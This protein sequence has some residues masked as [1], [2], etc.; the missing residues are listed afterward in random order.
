MNFI[1]K[2]L[3]M[4]AFVLLYLGVYLVVSTFI[5]VIYE[6]I[7]IIG[8]MINGS[9]GFD[10]NAFQSVLYQHSV[11]FTI[12]SAIVVIPIYWFIMWLRKLKMRDECGF[13]RIKPQS[14]LISALL[15]IAL[16]LPVDFIVSFLSIDKLSPGTEQIFNAMFSNNSVLVLILSVGLAAPILEEI[17]FRGLIFSELRRHLPI[18]IAIVIQGLL[19]GA[20]H[21]NWTQF[22]Y[23]APLG[24]LFGVV[25]IWVRSISA[26][27]I[28][29]ILFNSAGILIGKFFNEQ[30]IFNWYFVVLSTI[31]VIMLMLLIWNGKNKTQRTLKIKECR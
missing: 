10:P 20:I 19:F 15:G 16:V 11:Y 2:Y 6:L 14:M 24:I 12:I 3:K 5:G 13:Q 7:Y 21:M 25:Y 1:L 27:I 18:P 30:I 26:T 23:A 17:L 22:L 8:K 9:G 31:G 4:S 29:H 28:I